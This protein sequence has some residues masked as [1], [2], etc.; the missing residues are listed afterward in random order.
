MRLEQV[1][2]EIGCKDKASVAAPAGLIGVVIED[3]VEDQTEAMDAKWTF[4]SFAVGMA[5][6]EVVNEQG[7]EPLYIASI[8]AD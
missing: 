6:E 3:E 7:V 8:T 1:E 5:S 2:R 4:N